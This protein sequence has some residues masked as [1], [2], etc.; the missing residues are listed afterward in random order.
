MAFLV[1][2]RHHDQVD[3]RLEIATLD[4]DPIWASRSLVRRNDSRLPH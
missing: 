3:E 1:S 4:I 2:H